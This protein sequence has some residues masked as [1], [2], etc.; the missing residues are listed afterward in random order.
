MG[1]MTLPEPGRPVEAGVPDPWASPG[2]WEVRYPPPP[3]PYATGV[4]LTRTP[5]LPAVEL[6][7]LGRRLVARL[8]DVTTVTAMA[9][10]VAI[11]VGVGLVLLLGLG[12]KP[13]EE[14]IVLSI[15]AVFLTVMLMVS[16]A[17]FYGLLAACVAQFAVVI[18][19]TAISGR[20]LGKTI[21]GIR[22]DATS[23]RGWRALVREVVP[24]IIG[25][26]WYAL[27]S[28]VL[29]PDDGTTDSAAHV[30]FLAV[31]VLPLL[32]DLAPLLLGRRRCLHDLYAGTV[33]I[34]SAPRRTRPGR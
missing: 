6:A 24:I 29:R 5:Q 20:S 14:S 8:I 3:V 13:P 22:V 16:V 10:V 2:P 18:L 25:V 21:T 7:P 1:G 11:A 19:P 31:A 9:A 26:G 30:L 32:V 33:V 27:D 28:A 15:T 17:A 23:G 34:R 12:E 4:P